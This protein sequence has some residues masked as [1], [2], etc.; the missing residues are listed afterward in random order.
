MTV[1]DGIEIA[2]GAVIVLVAIYDIFQSVVMPRPAVGRVRLSFTL[3]RSGWRLWRKVAE[4]PRKL[5]TREAALAAF[6]PM[7]LVTL[8]VLWGFALILGYALIFSGLHAGLQPQPDSF[9]TTLYYS[10][11]QMLSFSVAGIEAT[12]VATRVFAAI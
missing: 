6:A 12:G 8:L 7:M 10:T 2:G 4:R 9:G 1:T 3:I 5:Q 11:G